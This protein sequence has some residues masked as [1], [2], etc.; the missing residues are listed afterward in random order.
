MTADGD[1]FDALADVTE[2]DFEPGTSWAYSNS[3]SFLM[4]QVVLAITGD[5]LGTFTVTG[6]GSKDPTWSARWKRH[7]GRCLP[8]ET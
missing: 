2:L 8:W 5:D 3:N 4:G 6:H 1:T 7:R